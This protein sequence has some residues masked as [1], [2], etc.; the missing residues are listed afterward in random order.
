MAIRLVFGLLSMLVM[1]TACAITRGSSGS[2]APN[3]VERD[4]H[5]DDVTLHVKTAGDADAEAV[6]IA[7]HG[8]P[9]TS[10]DYMTS[11]EQLAGDRLAVVTYDQRGTGRSS[12]PPARATNYTLA[13]YVADLEAVRQATGR[14]KVDLFGHSWGGILALRYA[15][16]HPERVDA[17]ILMGSGAPSRQA[18][19]AGEMRMAQVRSELQEQ[20][21][22]PRAIQTLDDVLPS[23]FSDPAFVAPDE[24]RLM[25]YSP[26][27]ESLTRE[28]LGSFDFVDQ[29]GQ[30]EHRVL[31]LYGMDDPFGLP[32]AEATRDAL[33]HADIEYIL[34]Q[35]CGH[36]WQECPDT[37]FRHVKTFL[38]LP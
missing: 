12:S 25:H 11:L 26:S 2:D 19:E 35:D 7:I 29:V 21:I 33:S 17:I 27:A 23:Y 32:M 6:L 36:F 38:N 9:G 16:V 13:K 34:L 30:L 24:L 31:V 28:A 15:T 20:G 4:V 37:F 8:G 18:V 5:A 3:V 14:D 1:T 10:S 22:M